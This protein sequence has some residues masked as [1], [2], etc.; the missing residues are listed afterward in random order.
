MT[1]FIDYRNKYILDGV[2]TEDNIISFYI[3]EQFIVYKYDGDIR[4]INDGNGVGDNYISY[5][6]SDVTYSIVPELCDPSLLLH[7]VNYDWI[8]ELLATELYELKEKYN[9]EY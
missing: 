3:D 2:D 7:N 9:D 5:D 8:S 6:D 1:S 4:F